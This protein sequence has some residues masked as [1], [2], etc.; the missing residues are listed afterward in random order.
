MIG[1]RLGLKHEEYLHDSIS[2][3]VQRYHLKQV[4]LKLSPIC[5]ILF[6]E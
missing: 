2:M 3:F 4:M 1:K 6:E 5:M